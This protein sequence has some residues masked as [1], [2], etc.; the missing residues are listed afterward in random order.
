MVTRLSRTDA[1]EWQGALGE[2]LCHAPGVPLCGG[3]CGRRLSRG[4]GWLVSVAAAGIGFGF[5]NTAISSIVIVI[6]NAYAFI[7]IIISVIMVIDD[8]FIIVTINIVI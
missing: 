2:A 5:F 6:V 8:I 3:A 4:R 7:V 1:R